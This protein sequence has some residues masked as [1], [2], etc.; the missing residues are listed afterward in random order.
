MKGRQLGR[1][2]KWVQA[3][4]GQHVRVNRTGFSFVVWEKWKRVENRVGTLTVS[5]GGLRWL[6]THGRATR[7]RT[8]LE[9]ADWLSQ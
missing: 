9:V 8:W 1:P 6:P 2:T 7:R 3:Q 4:I 5:V